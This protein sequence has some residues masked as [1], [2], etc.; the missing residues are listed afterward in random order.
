MR[1]QVNVVGVCQTK[2]PKEYY[3]EHASPLGETKEALAVMKRL[4]CC[5][6]GNGGSKST[7]CKV[8]LHQ[9]S[10][11]RH[12]SRRSFGRRLLCLLP[13]GCRIDLSAWLRA[14]RKTKKSRAISR[15]GG[16]VYDWCGGGF[17][18]TG[19]WRSASS[20]FLLEKAGYVCL[21]SLLHGCFH[22][23][24]IGRVPSIHNIRSV[25]TMT[26][27]DGAVRISQRL[28]YYLLVVIILKYLCNIFFLHLSHVLSAHH[29]RAP[30]Q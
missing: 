12:V 17:A 26:T 7:G 30:S 3:W 10:T 14:R 8:G 11:W 21:L 5:P 24:G 15:W 25:S 18:R 13:E 22:V 2:I 6:R 1:R 29:S 4:H 23:V 19:G 27:A 9:T 20:L 16:V 28:T